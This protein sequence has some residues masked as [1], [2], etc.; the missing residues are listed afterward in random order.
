MAGDCGFFLGSPQRATQ[1]HGDV[2]TLELFHPDRGSLRICDLA[3]AFHFDEVLPVEALLVGSFDY[4]IVELAGTKKLEV[5]LGGD[6]PIHHDGRNNSP[7]ERSLLQGAQA[8][9]H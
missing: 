5:G 1:H 9:E 7:K 3:E 8:I 2:I 6:S 4:H